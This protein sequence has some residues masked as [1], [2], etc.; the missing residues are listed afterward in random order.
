MPSWMLGDWFEVRRKWIGA[1][2]VPSTW[3]GYVLLGL[4]LV[5]GLISSFPEYLKYFS[6]DDVKNASMAVFFFLFVVV[7][8]KTNFDGMR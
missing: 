6:S 8:A 5:V 7:L 1:H 3:Q 4:I 2:I